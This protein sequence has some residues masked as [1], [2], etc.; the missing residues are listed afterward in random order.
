MK[1]K[2][3]SGGLFAA[4]Q[5]VPLTIRETPLSA[6][7]A[8]YLDNRGIY[9]DRLQC[10]KLQT[11]RGH[12]IHLCKTGT[13]D[14][15]CIIRGQIIFIEV[16]MRDEKPCAGQL[17]RHELLRKAGAIVIVADSFDGFRQQLT[18]IRAAI[19]ESAAQ[20]SEQLYD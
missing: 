13:P 10:G 14:R 18:A 6:Q 17:S 16:K 11:A 20:R 7:I 19:S 2:N 9:N 5:P 3:L 8:E 4:R 15:F 1:N 12:W